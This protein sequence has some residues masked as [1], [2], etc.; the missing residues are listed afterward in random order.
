MF[1]LC[2]RSKLQLAPFSKEAILSHF[3]T[4]FLWC[5]VFFFLYYAFRVKFAKC[6]F[7]SCKMGV[8]QSYLTL[9]KGLSGIYQ[10]FRNPDSE[11]C[12]ALM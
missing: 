2:F 3:Q 6:E 7:A 8:I 1:E 5:F 4:L 12:A 10:R 11:A 9:N